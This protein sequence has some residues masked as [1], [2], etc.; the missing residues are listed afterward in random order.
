MPEQTSWGLD[1]GQTTL[2][3]VRLERGKGG[4]VILADTFFYPLETTLDDPAYE[5][6]VLEG[7]LEFKAQ[8][9][10]GNVPVV[11]S[12][13]GYTTLFRHFPLPAVGG[14]RLRE[15]VS[16]E[17]KQLIPYDLNEVEWDYEQL[18]VD[19][20]TGEIEIA[21]VCCRSDIVQERLALLDQ[22]GLN[23]EAMQVGPVG[24]VNYMLHD[25]PPEG[26]SLILDAG[27][28]ST[29]FIILN[30]GTFWLRSIGVSGSDLTRALM[31]KFSIPFEDAE[32]LKAGLGENAQ[33]ERVKRVLQPMLRNLCGEVQRSLG[34]YKS[35][36]RGVDLDEIV[37]AGNTFLLEGADQFIADNLG[38]GAR[39]MGVPES[40]ELSPE[41]A[42][43][44]LVADAQVL[45][46][47]TGLAL[48]GI[49]YARYSINLLPEKRQ[50]RK[51]IKKKELFGW[52]AVALV[53]VTVIIGYVT[54]QSKVPMYVP[55]MGRIDSITAR[56]N[57]RKAEYQE[58]NKVFRPEERR[59]TAMEGDETGRGWLTEA[60]DWTFSLVESLNRQRFNR[61]MDTEAV[62]HL[63]SGWRRFPVSLTFYERELEEAKKAWK[64]EEVEDED[65]KRIMIQ[66]LERQ[67]ELRTRYVHDRQGRFFV[68]NMEFTVVRARHATDEELGTDSWTVLDRPQIP[69][70]QGGDARP[71]ARPPTP[72]ARPTAR[73]AAE[74]GEGDVRDVVFVR[75]GGFV[76]ST[77]QND[78]FT[79]RTALQ[80]PAVRN[81]V[82]MLS[83]DMRANVPKNTI[84]LNSWVDPTP[85]DVTTDEIGD[86]AELARTRVPGLE[87]VAIEDIVQ[88]TVEYLYF[89]N[90]PERVEPLIPEELLTVLEG[91]P[92]EPEAPP[93]E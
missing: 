68:N 90:T 70:P 25:Q 51:L 28:R 10:V 16:Y 79:L 26:V 58:K 41:V 11:V 72:A 81:D 88:F 8:K 75:L 69:D 13:P 29:D 22:V 18:R 42:E 24:M 27:A 9:K 12:L 93:V 78:A 14:G 53:A 19:V 52:I 15:I 64:V 87:A 44:D 57:E 65:R 46:I 31:N 91:A 39:T 54:S 59:V 48:Q 73:P 38:Y 40:F 76:V 47:A 63:M 85:I 30:D 32:Q 83:F 74:A 71:G 45:G 86:G 3:A 84:L 37:L 49:G 92:V 36:F 62:P 67:A 35:L 6:K 21:L 33:S 61:R 50:L 20:D 7:L 55:L 89:P 56:V 82:H 2:H 77:D 17:A 66:N 60:S 1:I 4:S 34:Y 43:A 5:D 80:S 23:V